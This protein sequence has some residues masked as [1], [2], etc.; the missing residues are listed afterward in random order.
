MAE[1]QP[2]PYRASLA[3]LRLDERRDRPHRPRPH[4]RHPADLAG[5]AA[6]A[7]VGYSLTVAPRLPPVAGSSR[8]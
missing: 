2:A 1:E 4:R 3:G 7:A 8:S 6:P 5:A